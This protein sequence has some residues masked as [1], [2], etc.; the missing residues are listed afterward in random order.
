M[1]TAQ[2]ILDAKGDD[3]WTVHPDDFVFDAIQEMADKDI[4]ALV[5]VENG[6][7]VGILS[8][9][10]YARN[11]ILKGKSSPKTPVR[12]IMVTRVVC[13][14]PG[15]TVEEC[16]AV[17][18]EKHVRHLPVLQNNKLV[19]MI[20]LGDVVKS[21]IEDKEHDIEELEHYIHTA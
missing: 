21:I 1:K 15:Q 18:T 19:G 5:V 4:G 8:E 20:S 16:M 7:L 9:R 2:H 12:N 10:D 11:V 17:M 3:V 14:R 6:K 13:A